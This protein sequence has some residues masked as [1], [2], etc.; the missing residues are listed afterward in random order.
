MDDGSG[1]NKLI[2]SILE[3]DKLD[4]PSSFTCLIIK[5]VNADDLGEEMNVMPGYPKL[6]DAQIVN[7]F[8]FV[9]HRFSDGQREVTMSEIGNLRKACQ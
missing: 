9:N 2:P 6:S 4:D 3:S 8:H 1:L 7:L 5:G